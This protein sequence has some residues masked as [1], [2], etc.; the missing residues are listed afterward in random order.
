LTHNHHHRA[1]S[2]IWFNW[3]LLIYQRCMSSKMNHQ[4]ISVKVKIRS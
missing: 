2:A 1:I 3:K 4:C